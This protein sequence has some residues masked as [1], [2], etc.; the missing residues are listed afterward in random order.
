MQLSQETVRELAALI[1]DLADYGDEIAD[2]DRAIKRG[3]YG[4]DQWGC[5]FDLLLDGWEDRSV[6]GWDTDGEN[7]SYFA[8]LYANGKPTVNDEPHVWITRDV[9]SL[10]QLVDEIANAVGAQRPEETIDAMADSLRRA[11][12]VQIE[13]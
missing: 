11:L 13:A 8:Q 1:D 4:G 6:W 9:Q 2:L 7:G 3:M 12:S 5:Q 10:N